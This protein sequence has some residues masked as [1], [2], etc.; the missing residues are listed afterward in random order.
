[1]VST[2]FLLFGSALEEKSKARSL[3]RR[4]NFSEKSVPKKMTQKL[5]N[6]CQKDFQKRVKFSNT[7]RR[8]GGCAKSSECNAMNVPLSCLSAKQPM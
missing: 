6:N 7:R 5:K 2:Q 1:L 8:E 3:V 4:K